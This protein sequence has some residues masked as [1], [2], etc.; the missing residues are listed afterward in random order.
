M[1]R[2]DSVQV[3]T[4]SF[5]Y[6]AETDSRPAQVYT[7]SV[8][9]ASPSLL[10]SDDKD[11]PIFEAGKRER[12]TIKEAVKILLIDNEKNVVRPPFK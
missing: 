4:P 9:T 10:Y 6:F 8:P 3:L 12:Y 7:S 1:V 2:L 5:V 11:L